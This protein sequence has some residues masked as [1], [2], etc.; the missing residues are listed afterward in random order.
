MIQVCVGQQNT[1]DPGIPER[2]KTRLKIRMGFDL[3]S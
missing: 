2:M 1:C 3:S